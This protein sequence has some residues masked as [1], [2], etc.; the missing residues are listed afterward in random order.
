MAYSGPPAPPPPPP[1][2][3]GQPPVG[4]VERPPRPTTVTAAVGL[5]F[6]AVVL[7]LVGSAIS[8]STSDTVND[9]IEREMEASGGSNT[10]NVLTQGLTI[11]FSLILSIVFVVL[12]LLLLRGSNGGRIATWV[13]TGIW[14]LCGFCGLAGG[15]FLLAID[16]I[17]G[18]L[19][20]YTIASGAISVILYIAIIVLLLL[21]ASN[22][23]F[24][25]KPQDQLY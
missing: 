6:F 22:A 2:L 7:N 16:G 3:P 17:P 5:M 24:K 25:P 18:W 15:F 19:I 21:P 10:N 23:Y 4:P 8:I 1:Q 9:A 12:A 13:V 14:L 11:G 20:G